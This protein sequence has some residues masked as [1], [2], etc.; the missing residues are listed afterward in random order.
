VIVTFVS[1]CEKNA[2]P[3]TR[4]VLDAFA[5]RIGDRVWQTAITD[6]GLNAVKKLLRKNASKNTAV[7]C[8]LICGHR[9]SKLEWIVGNRQKFNAQGIVP[10][11]VTATDIVNTQWENDWRY[12]PLIKSL[13][14]LAGLFHD[15]GKASDFFQEKLKKNNCE[16]DPIRHEWI[17]VLLLKAVVN[18]EADEKWLRRLGDGT[19]DERN[20]QLKNLE[21]E[22]AS[23]ETLPDAAKLIAWLILSHHRMPYIEKDKKDCR[24]VKAENLQK[25]L[26]ILT[27]EWGYAN[28]S[29][30]LQKK[31]FAFSQGLPSV[32]TQKFHLCRCKFLG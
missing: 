10:V 16:S 2:L 7:S 23:L 6:D 9:Q 15:W 5:N 17:S 20:L 31:C 22:D 32:Y 4:R 29:N 26:K 12:L 25:V 24:D 11:N 27:K 19:I 21:K 30:G 13:C 18:G 3:K 8:H 28:A 14:A 1:Q